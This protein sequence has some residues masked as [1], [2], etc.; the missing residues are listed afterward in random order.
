LEHKEMSERKFYRHYKSP[1]QQSIVGCYEEL[2]FFEDHETCASLTLY[3]P[4]YHPMVS[5]AL[6]FARPTQEFL[7]FV[8]TEPRFKRITDPE[9]I[10]W[11]IKET[12]L[13]YGK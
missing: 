1:D 6:G 9:L 3:R 4:C 5:G 12:G 2:G 13:I 7:G 10:E 8:G 11:C